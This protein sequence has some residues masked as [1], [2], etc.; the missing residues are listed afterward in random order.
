MTKKWPTWP[1]DQKIFYF[2]ALLNRN[3]PA[4]RWSGCFVQNVP[5]TEKTIHMS[6]VCALYSKIRK[7][8]I[9]IWKTL[10]DQMKNRFTRNALNSFWLR[11]INT[12]MTYLLIIWTLSLSSD[13][14]PMTSK[15][16]THLNLKILEQGGFA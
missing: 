15:I 14:V 12:W 3:L 4:V 11:F 6:D 2:P 1:T 13:K 7:K 16:S 10:R 8:T 5:F 9:W